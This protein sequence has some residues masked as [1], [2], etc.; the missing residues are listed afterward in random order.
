MLSMIEAAYQILKNGA[1]P[2][3]YREIIRQALEQ[4]LISTQGLTPEASLVSAISRENSKH[5]NRG[6]IPRFE[7]QGE[8]IY[9]LAEWKPVGIVRSINDIKRATRKALH[10]RITSMPP[11]LFEKLIGSLLEKLG[12]QE[13]TVRVTGR[14]GDGGIDVI[15]VMNIEDITELEVA[16]QVK[17]ISRN[18]PPEKIRAL[19]GALMPNQRGI[20]ITTS[21]FTSQAEQ[22]ACAAGKVPISL[23]DGEQLLD[24]LFV[25]EIGVISQQHKIY[26]IEADY[27]KEIPA[28]S[29]TIMSS[30]NSR[31]VPRLIKIQ[32]PLA[33]FAHYQ[34]LSIDASLLADGQVIV[35]QEHFGSLSAAGMAVTRW[36]SCNGWRFWKFMNPLDGQECLVDVLRKPE[37]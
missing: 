6:E 36:K 2:M 20:F 27:W 3:H 11:E 31:I 26:E 22:E 12:F 35:D 30:N 18:V 13:G 17:R 23:V 4:Q 16:V 9:G 5:S 25:H 37:S 24:L 19:R 33:I 21:K 1:T 32:Y 14:S 34:E 8:G 15:G 10:E 7:L 28:A 29:S